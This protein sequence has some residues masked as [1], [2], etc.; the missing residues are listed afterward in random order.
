M[1]MLALG[2]AALALLISGAT[3]YYQ[4][5]SGA[6]LFLVLG[7]NFTLTYDKKRRLR[8]IL[9]VTIVN[10][11]AKTGIIVGLGGTIRSPWVGTNSNYAWHALADSSA[12]GTASTGF[13]PQ[14]TVDAWVRTLLIPGMD[15]TVHRIVF[16]TKNE[17]TLAPGKYEITIVADCGPP[18]HS[19]PKAR[20]FLVLTEKDI[21]GMEKRRPAGD[22]YDP[23][24]VR[25]P[26]SYGEAALS[27]HVPH[28]TA[29]TNASSPS[30]GNAS[31][32]SASA[33]W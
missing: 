16:R 17:L 26:G 14:R 4:T 8:F 28:A 9:G 25:V 1:D 24:F 15:A 3:F 33:L 27:D 29:G 12:S 7:E 2:I 32:R 20:I 13:S 19:G 10:K 5:I 18:R 6:D 30:G 31:V 11:G 21:D 22:E 23:W